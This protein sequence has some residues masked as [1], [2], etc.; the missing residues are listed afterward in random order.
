M[1]ALLFVF[2]TKYEINAFVLKLNHCLLLLCRLDIWVVRWVIYCVPEN[3]DGRIP[4]DG[5]YI[6]DVQN[7]LSWVSSQACHSVRYGGSELCEFRRAGMFEE[8]ERYFKRQPV[9][10]IGKVIDLLNNRSGI[11]S[12]RISRNHNLGIRFFYRSWTT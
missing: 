4:L 8:S 5:P 7:I 1:L 11:P 6:I 10:A 9:P 12:Y 2:Y 3:M